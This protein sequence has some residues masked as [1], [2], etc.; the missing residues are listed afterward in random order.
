MEVAEIRAVAV[1]AVEIFLL[2][3]NVF[4]VTFKICHRVIFF[5]ADFTAMLRRFVVFEMIFH[6]F[7]VLE[8]LLA[9][10]TWSL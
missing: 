8:N 10:R 9:I 7:A 1:L 6:G 4:H 2:M 5:L 3:V